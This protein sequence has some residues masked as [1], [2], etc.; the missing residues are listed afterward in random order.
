MTTG[1][2]KKISYIALNKYYSMIRLKCSKYRSITY[3]NNNPCEFSFNKLSFNCK[4]Y[5]NDN[6]KND[7]T[8]EWENS[9]DI[10]DLLYEEYKNV[11]PLTLRF[12]ELEKMI[13]ETVVNKNK[14]KLSGSCNESVLENIQMNWLERYNEEIS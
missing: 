7:L 3:C 10:V 8:L 9:D 6:T 1:K 4:R 13:I 5:L 12:E 2:V 14:K 11:D